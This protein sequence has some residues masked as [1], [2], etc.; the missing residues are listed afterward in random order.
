MRMNFALIWVF[1]MTGCVST[2][3][4]LSLS[5][6]IRVSLSAVEIKETKS[7]IAKFPLIF[8]ENEFS[9]GVLVCGSVA[10]KPDLDGDELIYKFK[11]RRYLFNGLDE[12]EKSDLLLVSPNIKGG[13]VL[14]VPNIEYRI[15]APK[16]PDKRLGVWQGL[17]IESENVCGF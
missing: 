2:S 14:L 17:V 12:R 4:E 1:A 7:K 13:G 15:F 5:K 16:L 9:G 10:D 3:G 11:V 8:D 6:P